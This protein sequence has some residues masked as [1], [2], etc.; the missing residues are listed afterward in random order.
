[1]IA[2][3]IFLTGAE[4]IKAYELFDRAGRDALIPLV[5]GYTKLLCRSCCVS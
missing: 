2:H 4:P 5:N 3:Y 1:M